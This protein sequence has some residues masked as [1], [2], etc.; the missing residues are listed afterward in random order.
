MFLKTS[1]VD[2]IA[3]G[4]EATMSLVDNAKEIEQNINNKE[5]F[6]KLILAAELFDELE[7][8]AEASIVTSIL[9][10]SAW[11]VPPS[12]SP[13]LDQMLNNLKDH[14]TVFQAPKSNIVPSSALHGEKTDLVPGGDSHKVDDSV[15]VSIE[16]SDE[17]KE[18]EKEDEKEESKKDKKEDVDDANEA[19]DGE[20]LE[21]MIPP[22][23]Q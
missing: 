18:D 15:E 2:E 9:E 10:K 21:V 13:S 6:S 14:G 5:A 4:L 11:H 19:K 20:I 1:A 7:L 8:D 3:Q 17:D 22:D 16:V 12:D 23:Q